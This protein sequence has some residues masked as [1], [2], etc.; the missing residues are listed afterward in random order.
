MS[1]EAIATWWLI[2]LGL[3]AVIVVAAA[4]LLL[5]I[6]A[7]AH[8]NA[9]LAGTALEV[10]SDIEVTTR[11]IWQINATNRVAEDLAGGAEAIA[12]NAEAISEALD[13]RHRTS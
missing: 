1:A 4:A 3:G 5:T 11:P 8:R 2:W 10:V 9:R 7:L 12:G 6:I 13:G